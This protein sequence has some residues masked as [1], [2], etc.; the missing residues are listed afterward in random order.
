MTKLYKKLRE[1]IDKYWQ[2][3]DKILKKNWQNFFKK[4]RKLKENNLPTN[5]QKFADST[6]TIFQPFFKILSTICRQI[7]N[8]TL[9]TS[10]AGSATL[11][12]TSWARLT[13][14]W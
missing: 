8:N 14:N 13:M 12:D 1:K 7:A 4:L 11:E 10:L 5:W 6:H 3:F 9:I 2:L